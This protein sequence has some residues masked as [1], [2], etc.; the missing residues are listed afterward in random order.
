MPTTRP[1]HQ[2]TETPEIAAA[3]DRAEQRWPGEPRSRLLIRLIE[4]GDD[5]SARSEDEK[6]AARRRAIRETAGKYS[7]AFPPGYLA[8]LRED[9]P[10]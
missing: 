9:W 8:E 4:A 3:L 1:R 2:V 7:G 10:E 6:I 5:A